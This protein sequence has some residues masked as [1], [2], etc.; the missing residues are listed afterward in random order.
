MKVTLS[1]QVEESVR[2]RLDEL[3]RVISKRD[4]K[5]YKLSHVI[6]EALT[7]YIAGFDVGNTGRDES[8]ND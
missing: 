8:C 7:M 5:R 1:V 4:Y 2:D 3:V 6:R